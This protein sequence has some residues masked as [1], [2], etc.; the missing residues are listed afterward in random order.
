MRHSAIALA[1]AA[2]VALPAQAN[3]FAPQLEELARTEIRSIL[4]DPALIE[5]IRTQNGRTA[6]LSETE[7][8]SMDQDWRGQIGGGS[9]PLID[10]V[11]K[12]PAADRLRAAQQASGGLFTEIFLM[13]AVGL[14]V[15]ASDVTSDYWQGDE[16]KWQKTY[17]MGTDTPHIGDVELDESTQS[18][19]SQ[20]SVAVVDPDTGAPIGAATFGINVEFLQ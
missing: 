14:N 12:G 7:I 8:T 13:D 5:A 6:G 19:Q 15:A 17:A 16:A 2:T 18:Y 20:V 1:L 4:N 3:E 11:T 10:A 9:A